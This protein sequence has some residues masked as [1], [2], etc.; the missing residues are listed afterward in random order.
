MQVMH[1]ALVRHRHNHV[2]FGAAD[3]PSDATAVYAHGR[4]SAPA[5]IAL[6]PANGKTSSVLCAGDERP[7]FALGTVITR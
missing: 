2:G 3:M 6:I 4:G 5:R 1:T 7:F